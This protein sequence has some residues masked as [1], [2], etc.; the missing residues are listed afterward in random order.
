MNKREM[1]TTTIATIADDN[2]RS[3][4]G[5]F[6]AVSDAT[7]QLNMNYLDAAERLL[8]YFRNK[9]QSQFRSDLPS[10]GVSLPSISNIRYSSPERNVPSVR[11]PSQRSSL[12]SL[13]R[14]SYSLSPRRNSYS[15]PGSN[16]FNLSPIRLPSN[17]RNP[18]VGTD[19]YSLPPI[20]GTD[21]YSLPPIRG[22]DSYSLPSL[23]RSSGITL[24]PV[25]YSP[26][27][28][29]NSPRSLS[30]LNRSSGGVSLSQANRSPGGVSLP[31]VNY[32]SSGISLP[33]LPSPRTSQSSPRSLPSV[34][35][36]GL[37]TVGGVLP[38]V[39]F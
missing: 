1:Y 38:L 21:S 7:R 22:A 28:S 25:N 17:S 37:P 13:S 29:Q 39:G 6:R 30:P 10:V 36:L 8:P 5:F 33:G 20:R 35:G 27:T 12:S 4:D 15:S 3:M 18:L 24:P 32:S 2:P 31:P 14:D 34:S 19:S 11:L 9:R 26:R 23:N 16:N